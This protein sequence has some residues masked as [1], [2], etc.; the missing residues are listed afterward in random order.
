[1]CSYYKKEKGVTQFAGY[2]DPSNENS[3]KMFRR[4]GF[5][6]QGLGEVMGVVGEGVGLTCYVWTSGVGEREEELRA[7]G[8]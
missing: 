7:V 8:L 1:M 4:L 6:E 3:M 5:H 2:C